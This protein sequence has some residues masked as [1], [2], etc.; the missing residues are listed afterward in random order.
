MLLLS[1]ASAGAS[2][3]AVLLESTAQR[4]VDTFSNCTQAPDQPPDDTVHVTRT[5]ELSPWSPLRSFRSGSVTGQDRFESLYL[6]AQARLYRLQVRLRASHG[7]SSPHPIAVYTE[8]YW[9]SHPSNSGPRRLSRRC[10]VRSQ[11]RTHD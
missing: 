10:G 8:A 4:C 7:V 1:A 5:A 11:V 6:Q 3:V 9:G 2:A